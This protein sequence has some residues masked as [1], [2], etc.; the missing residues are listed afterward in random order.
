MQKKAG[1][2]ALETVGYGRIEMDAQGSR[3]RIPAG[4]TLDLGGIAKGYVVQKATEMLRQAGVSRAII[5]AGGDISVIGKRPP[6]GQPWRVGVQDPAEP[7]SLR[8]I[9]ALDDQCIV[10]SGDYQRYFEEDG[11]RWHH[12]LDPKSG[13]PA[14]GLHSVTVVGDDIV[15]CDAAATAIF[16]LG[17]EEGRRLALEL[18]GL[19]AILVGEH[20][21]EWI[22][23]GLQDKI[24]SQ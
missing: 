20:G 6:D 4:T 5:N 19:E 2:A 11:Q 15:S 1:G 14:R 16:V 18:D 22:S 23:P 24:I 7:A 9:L 21:G 17:W 13:Y 10:T 8:W 12:L 3:V